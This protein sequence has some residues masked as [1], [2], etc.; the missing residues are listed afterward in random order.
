MLKHWPQSTILRRDKVEQEKG[1]GQQMAHE[2]CRQV[3]V[4][5]FLA[6]R[7]VQISYVAPVFRG[8][9]RSN[10]PFPDSH[11]YIRANVICKQLLI[12]TELPAATE[13]LSDLKYWR[14]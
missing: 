11:Y 14:F 13:Q 1:L 2:D 5:R 12:C 4:D 6:A 9:K 7:H 10:S 8:D 3:S